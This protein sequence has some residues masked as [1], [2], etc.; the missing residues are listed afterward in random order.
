MNLIMEKL[1][2]VTLF[3]SENAQQTLAVGIKY[4]QAGI[5]FNL[6]YAYVSYLQN[7]YMQKEFVFIK[8]K[9]RVQNH[10]YC[11]MTYFD[12][13]MMIKRERIPK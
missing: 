13:I 7:A 10:I 3:L 8:C 11:R 1:P 6:R 2:D 4:F 5:I 12:T 9:L